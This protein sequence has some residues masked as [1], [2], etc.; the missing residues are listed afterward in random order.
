[1]QAKVSQKVSRERVERGVWRRHTRDGA[2]RY[3]VAFLDGDGRQ[4]WRTVATLREARQLRADLVSKVGHGERVTS[5]RMTFS[6]FADEWLAGQEAR[7]RPKTRECYSTNLRLHVKPRLGRRRIGEITADDVARLVGEIEQEG[8]AAW[9]ISGVLTVL[10][11][12]L[13][14]AERRGLIAANPVRRLEKGERPR[15]E[16][17]EFPALDHAAIGRLIAGAPVKYRTLIALSLLTGVRQSEALGLRWSDVDVRV[18]VVRVRRQLD[19]SGALVEPKTRAAK[20]DIPIP[21]SLARLLAEHRLE[22]RYSAGDEFVFCS[23]VG[24]PLGHRGIV[25]RGLQPA[26]VAAG[27]PHL[28]WHD[29]RHVAASL[30]IA[31]GMSVPYIACVL[32]HA[33]PAIT[34]S[35]YAHVFA[36]AE[37]GDRARE[38]MELAFGEVLR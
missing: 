30:M 13:G 15:I 2:T 36:S 12:V 7:L 6:E 11:R 35:T 5:S 1:M 19:R 31:E 8:K 37:H 33:S 24:T 23:S 18:G 20:R 14:A 38:R 34:L 21:A 28:R 27:L 29:L 17:R 32:G 3:E 4:R 10:G 25:R 9:T 26:L 16:R 22:S